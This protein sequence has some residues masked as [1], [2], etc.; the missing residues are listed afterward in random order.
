MSAAQDD[1]GDGLIAWA[2]N[3]LEADDERAAVQAVESQVSQVSQS[4]P[5]ASRAPRATCRAV[6]PIEPSAR[7]LAPR[8]GPSLSTCRCQ[9]LWRRMRC[10]GLRPWQPRRRECSNTRR[11]AAY[12]VLHAYRCRE[13]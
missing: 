13:R 6:Y 8:P 7:S 3:E 10:W 5:G 4:G 9:T 1:L 12:I 2:Q 11:P